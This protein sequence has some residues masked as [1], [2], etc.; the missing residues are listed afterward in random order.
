[1]RLNAW[2][3]NTAWVNGRL[4]KVNLLYANRMAIGH[5]ST[6]FSVWGNY[7]STNDLPAFTSR[8]NI[9]ASNAGGYI[10]EDDIR[11]A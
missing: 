4:F 1:M 11:A 2:Y 9:Y 5:N 8:N 7:L 3:T 6:E 10:T